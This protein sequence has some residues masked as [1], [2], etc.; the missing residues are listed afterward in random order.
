M[1]GPR[2]QVLEQTAPGEAWHFIAH[3]ARYGKA[4]AAEAVAMAERLGVRR[5]AI[6]CGRP[7]KGR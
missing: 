3:G 6:A 2:F 7:R 1:T 4:E 5:R